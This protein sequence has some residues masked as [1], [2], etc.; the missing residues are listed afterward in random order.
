VKQQVLNVEAAVSYPGDLAKIMDEGGYT[1][2]QRM[3]KKQ[4]YIVRSC[5]LGLS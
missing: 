5:H 4:P 1:K 3:E 2:Q